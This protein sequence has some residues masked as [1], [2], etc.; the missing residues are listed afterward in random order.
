MG[1]TS[2]SLSPP[3]HQPQPGG[4]DPGRF[5]RRRRGRTRL[6]ATLDGLARKYHPDRARRPRMVSGT[7]QAPLDL[8][9]EAFTRLRRRKVLAFVAAME[10]QGWRLL[11]DA[12]HPVR[13]EAGATPAYD[14]DLGAPRPGWREYVVSGWFV[15]PD[16]KPVRVELPE[17][18][19]RTMPQT[20]AERLDRAR[21]RSA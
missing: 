17:E 10:A 11:V 8:G 15:F 5:Y 16:P 9:V 13:L 20:E 14:L 19:L 2:T 1:S 12:R 3:S 21:E 7:F 4:L 6:A 18:L